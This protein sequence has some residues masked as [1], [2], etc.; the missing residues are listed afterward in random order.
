MFR[1]TKNCFFT[2]MTFFGCNAIKCVS[3]NNQEC[4]VRSEILNIN[5][6][7]PSFYPCSILVNKCSNSCNNINDPYAKLCVRDVI[8]NMN[9][10]VFN[11]IS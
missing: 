9:M 3:V 10:K 5:T 4:K 7:G 11:L 8:K 1:F 2:A 6:S